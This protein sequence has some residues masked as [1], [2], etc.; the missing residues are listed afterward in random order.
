MKRDAQ[1]LEVDL[2]RVAQGH[3]DNGGVAPVN[4][5]D[6]GKDRIEVFHAARQRAD[7]PERIERSAGAGKVAGTG[8]RPEVG[9]IA[10]MPVQ[11]AGK[12][13]LPPASLPKP[14]GD[15]PAAMMADS[16]PLLPP[17][18]SDRS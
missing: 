11:W 2:S 17:G 15:P 4:S 7:L 8:T 3:R 1:G 13:T 16:P 14:K 18:E 10:V 12:R 9:L 5:G 6:N